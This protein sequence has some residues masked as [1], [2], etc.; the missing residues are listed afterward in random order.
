[1]KK[2]MIL[3]VVV[4]YKSALSQYQDSIYSVEIASTFSPI[5]SLY[6]HPRYNGAAN[7]ATIGYGGTMRLMWFPARML[8]VGIMT[9]YL[10][11][12]ED[13][14]SAPKSPDQK[15]SASA[16]LTAIP[17]QVVVSMQNY[18]IELGL[19]M[20][21]YL[22]MTTIDYGQKARG[23]RLELGLTAYTSYVF[24]VKDNFYIGPELK[25]LYLSYR[26]IISIMPSI[27]IHFDAYRY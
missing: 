16:S 4:L 6:D 14:I 23:K 10:F 7:D 5:I 24:K 17:L 22:I 20:G 2:L 11:L 3:L 18:N 19:G 27:S 26:G 21:P 9:G 12:V 25:F 1:M 8:S 13:K 15:Y